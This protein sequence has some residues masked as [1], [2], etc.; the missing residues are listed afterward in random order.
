M[1]LA[2]EVHRITEGFP[3]NERFGLVAQTRRAAMSISSNIAEGE[4]RI[5]RREWLHFLGVARA[6]LYEL[7]SQLEF[8]LRVGRIAPE[9]HDNLTGRVRL[10]AGMLRGLMNHVTRLTP[11]ST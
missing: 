8:C 6:S 1:D 10:I 3:H 9:I 5:S 2:V 11:G 4:G 7:D